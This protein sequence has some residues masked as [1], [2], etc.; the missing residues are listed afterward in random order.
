MRF[1]TSIAAVA[2]L[3]TL[4]ANT[5]H[6]Y[7]AL[8]HTLTGQIAQQFLT[9]TTASQI[10][11]ILPASYGGLLSNAAPWADTVR[12]I[13]QYSADYVYAGQDNVN[14]ILNMTANLI[15]FQ[16]TPPTTAA[17]IKKRQDS[18]RFF[19]HFMGDVHQPL[20]DSTPLR[21][22]NDAPITWGTTTNNLHHM[23]DTLIITKDVAD[24][25]NNDD[26][27]YL[28]DTVNLAKTHWTDVSTWT[29]CD[30]TR[31]N[32]QNPWSTTTN[33]LKT[34]CP[35]QWAVDINALDCSYVWV[36]YSATRDYSTDYFQTVTGSSSDF[37]VQ[38]LLATSGVRMA[39]VLNEIYDPSAKAPLTKRGL[40]RLPSEH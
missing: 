28:D 13:K 38:K 31:N 20:H 30:P 37:L 17:A 15:K 25:F 4:G 8:G 10:S 1:S 3:I 16:Q 14:A 18:L 34:L 2:A 9:P 29:Y 39:A 5:A 35:I 11:A 21:G 19:I 6:A 26:Q 12:G 33:S 32:F 27:A 24:R 22:G 40:A 36:D 7:G 23:W